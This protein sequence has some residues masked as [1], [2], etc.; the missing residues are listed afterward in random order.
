M[1]ADLTNGALETFGG[2]L[3]LNHCRV[4]LRDKDV[5]G[6]SVV[7]VAL[8]ATWGAWN[9]Y[10][11]PSLGQWL[12]FAGGLCPL[13]ANLLWIVLIMRFRRKGQQ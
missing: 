5:A 10:Y 7:S 4:T 6:V 11:Y 8:F 9:L 2:L 12:S 1:W 13:L 3:I